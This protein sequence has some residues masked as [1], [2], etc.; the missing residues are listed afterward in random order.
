MIRS[1]SSSLVEEALARHAH[2]EHE[3][4]HVL[5]DE[6]ADGHRF[7]HERLISEVNLPFR[8]GRRVISLLLHNWGPFG[9]CAFLKPHEFLN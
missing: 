4:F 9:G 7:D 5:K 1:M 2:I 6:V 8:F 3:R